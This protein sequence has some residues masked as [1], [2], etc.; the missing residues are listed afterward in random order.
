MM[1]GRRTLLASST[2]AAVAPGLLASARAW[3]QQAPFK[4]EPDAKLVLLR[5]ATFLPAEGETTAAHVAAFAQATGTEVKILNVNQ[6]D[7]VSKMALSAQVG[8]GPDLIWTQNTTAHLFPDKLVDLTEVAD[9]LGG[10]YGG[11]YPVCEDYGRDAGR[12]ICIPVFI[13]GSQLNYRIRWMHEAGSDVMPTDTAGFLKLCQGLQRIGHP[14]GFS[15]G[16]A[17]NDANNFAYWL[18]WAF[19]GQ[20]ADKDARVT[21][22]SPQTEQAIAFA[23]GLYPTLMPGVMGWTDIS[24]N[25]AFVAG[26]C[27]LTNNGI[28]TYTQAKRTAPEIAAD[29][30]H[31]AMPIGPVGFATE[32]NRVDPM[33]VF[34]YS[35]YPN[36]AKALIAYLMES[37]RYKALI[38][39]SA[40]FIA[41]SLKA[42]ADNPIWRSDPKIAPFGRAPT[43]TRSVSWPRTPDQASA[44]VFANFVL[45]DMFGSAVS[46]ARSPKD[47]MQQAQQQAE[48]I[49]RRT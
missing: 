26:Q 42:F 49:Y 27:S 41:Q 8:S 34:R 22:A 47:A 12:W 39:N 5:G 30:D 36:A 35:K 4:P 15:F 23:R 37:P 25:Q 43:N 6:D 19:G 28:S 13:V 21:L 18:L 17:V 9:Y 48:R 45:V 44:A 24:N 29:M 32:Q 14:A 38:T 46:G 33:V 3:A 10:K 2:A 16:H 20:V 7:L 31:A 11:W 1:L 40:G